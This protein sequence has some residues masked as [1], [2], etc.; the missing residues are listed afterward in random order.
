M[1]TEL[2]M[3]R[4]W[5]LTF[6]THCSTFS[7]LTSA[8]ALSS[9]FPHCQGSSEPFSSWTCLLL[10][11]GFVFVLIYPTVTALHITLLGFYFFLPRK[12]LE[13]LLESVRYYSELVFKLSA[14]SEVVS[15]YCRQNFLPQRKQV[16]NYNCC[17]NR[18]ANLTLLWQIW[19]PLLPKI[20]IVCS[21][22]T[23]WDTNQRSLFR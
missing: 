16:L 9:S 10:T 18:D 7:A 4:R 6:C 23:L 5:Q 8:L 21:C 3:N 1:D 20:N 14:V 22:T 17:S 11:H 13:S 2:P 12:C 15:V 19:I